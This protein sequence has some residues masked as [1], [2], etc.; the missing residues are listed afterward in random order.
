MELYDEFTNQELVSKMQEISNKIELEKPLIQTGLDN[1]TNLKLEYENITKEFSITN[2]A[3][4][5]RVLYKASVPTI[6]DYFNILPEPFLTTNI[7]PFRESFIQRE[8]KRKTYFADNSF[9]FLTRVSPDNARL[10]ENLVFNYLKRKYSEVFY[11][12]TSNNLEVDFYIND[13][14]K[15]IRELIQASYS[16]E[17]VS[18]FDREINSLG[19][20]MEEQ[21][22]Q[23]GI[24]YTFNQTNEVIVGQ[25]K[26]KIIPLWYEM[27]TETE[28][29]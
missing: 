25:K 23:E 14:E 16:L 22:L 18:T 29:L 13:T 24:I 1:I 11:Y 5:I 10:F 9:I 26:I 8:T 28:S 4:K 6:T 7:Y 20:A 27:L 17:S 3:N 21:K 12:K 19:K 15:Q 2:L